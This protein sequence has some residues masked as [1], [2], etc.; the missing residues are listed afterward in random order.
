MPS[1]DYFITYLQN[2]AGEGQSTGPEQLGAW[3]RA[4]RLTGLSPQRSPLC[5]R[6][7]VPTRT[8][9]V[10]C[11]TISALLCSALR[12][13]G[14]LLPQSPASFREETHYKV[15]RSPLSPPPFFYQVKQGGRNLL[16]A[17]KAPN[18]VHRCF[19]PAWEN[20]SLHPLCSRFVEIR[21]RPPCPS[22]SWRGLSLWALIYILQ[23]FLIPWGSVFGKTA[24][25]RKDT[26]SH[27]EKWTE[28]IKTAMTV[29]ISE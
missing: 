28:S 25:A 12:E 10:S 18:S 1:D 14:A 4:H 2:R 3:I 13:S 11:D 15:P 21:Y 26:K 29:I 19:L 16:K 22:L 20:S 7:S 6:S 17:S 27:N 23:D 9:S 5:D 8:S 24:N